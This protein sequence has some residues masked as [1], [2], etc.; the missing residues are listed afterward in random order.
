MQTIVAVVLCVGLAVNAV[1]AAENGRLVGQV[2]D[3]TTK[4]PLPDAVVAVVGTEWGAATDGEGRFQIDALPEGVYKLSVHFM[5][6]HSLF[7]TDVRV[8]RDKVTYVEAV[9]LK[10]SVIEGEETLVSAGYFREDAQAPVSSFTYTRDE[11]RRTPGATGDIFRA[12]ETLP[13]VSTSGGEFAAFS[14]RGGS[15]KENIIL[16]DNI[17]FDK[18]SHF[19]GGSTEEQ[20]KQGG[21]FSIF[22][23]NLI[24]EARFQAGGFSA[25][26]GG[27]LASFLDIR[28]KEG[29]RQTPTVDGRFD[30]TGW[31]LNYDGPAYLHSGTSLVLSARHTD[32]ERILNQTGQDDLGWPRFDDL[33]VKS[34]TALGARHVVSLLGIYAPEKFDR[35]VGHVL[36][37]AGAASND[38]VDFQESKS[39]LGLNW[40]FLTGPRSVLQT[41]VYRRYTDR[42]VRAG[43]A[44]PTREGADRQDL[45]LT[46]Y[47]IEQD[48]EEREVGLRSVFTQVRSARSTWMAGVELSQLAIDNGWTQYGVDTLYVYSAGDRRPDPSQRFIVRRPELVNAD[49]GADKSALAAFGEW[50]QRATARLTLNAGLRYVRGAFNG[51]HY[52]APRL[53][54]SYSVNDRTRL[55]AAG[56]VHYQAPDLFVLTASPSNESLAHARAGHLIAGVTHYL[57]DDVKWTTEAYYK[58]FDRLPVWPDRTVPLRTSDGEGWAAGI[59]VSV[60]KR[61]VDQFYGQVNY[62]Y[63]QSKR[64]DGDGR[65]SYNADFNQPHI[66]NVLAGYEVN[67]T[68]SV[69]GKW[70]YATGRPRDG[71]VV[72]ADVLNDPERLRYAQEIVAN[73]SERLPAFHTLNLRLDARRQLGRMALVGFIDIVNLYG[74]LNV[75]EERFLELSGQVEERGFKI[76]PTGGMRVEF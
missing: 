50:S 64:D 3:G 72:H 42:L 26:Y 68:W 75:N 23:P 27:K 53:S 73:N 33:I 36:N 38:I 28:L 66:L 17:P 15:P 13:G 56:S 41:S 61:F 62:S 63:A 52:W 21:R 2:L 8:V 74:H 46:R 60:V 59:D 48:N 16:I 11:I 18:I 22:A 34:T 20:N 55:N 71:F 12:M 35:D 43:K 40:R 10:Q 5:G 47:G 57:R 9:E 32:F 44:W 65:G 7:K 1:G 31:E 24:E 45:F 70:R 51:A 14:V 4:Q 6:Y 69:A 37:S 30:V 58:R 67:K 54:A 39:L 29:N 49:V 25:Q 76:L 19:N